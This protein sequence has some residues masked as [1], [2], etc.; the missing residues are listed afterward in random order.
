MGSF[1]RPNYVETGF[2]GVRADHPQHKP[3]M[4]ALKD[5]YLS[6]LIFRLP[7]WHDCFALDYTRKRFE[8]AF[9]I[10]T[11]NFTKTLEGSGSHPISNSKLGRYIDHTKGP[12][13]DL[14]HSPEN[15]WHTQVINE[16]S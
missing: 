15:K 2:W 4:G 10:R 11:V 14:G 12:R 13:K 5:V 6:G 3:F 16:R 9:L 8:Q 1:E 7:Q